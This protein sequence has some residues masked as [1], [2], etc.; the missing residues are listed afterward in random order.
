ML[1]CGLGCL[2]TGGQTFCPSDSSCSVTD[3]PRW[4]RL[5]G[6]PSGGWLIYRVLGL[7]RVRWRRADPQVFGEM[8]A[9]TAFL[10]FCPFPGLRLVISQIARDRFVP[11]LESCS[12]GGKS[13]WFLPSL[14]FHRSVFPQT[15]FLLLSF[16]LIQVLLSNL[17][18]LLE[19]NRL[20]Q[21]VGRDV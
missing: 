9:W 15:G 12:P 5:G 19:V 14:L 16:S 2:A 4:P 18:H 10:S 11:A 1:G 13:R 21:E 7:P 17:F 8:G 20:R 6:F 3:S